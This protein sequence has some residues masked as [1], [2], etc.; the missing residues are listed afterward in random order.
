MLFGCDRPGGEIG[1]RA[2]L[3]GDLAVS[4]AGG[5]R[6]QGHHLTVF[7]DTIRLTIHA[8]EAAGPDGPAYIADAMDVSG[9]ER[10]GHGV[11]LVR[12]R[13]TR[14]PVTTIS[15]TLDAPS[16]GVVAWANAADGQASAMPSAAT[17]LD[18]RR[19]ACGMDPL[20]LFTCVGETSEPARR[21]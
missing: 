8:G 17:A 21:P 6:P 10:I 9:A 11:E 4:H 18:C 16:V 12:D 13:A 19:S 14:E 1:G 2:H 3:Q 20:P 15:S 5:D 7:D